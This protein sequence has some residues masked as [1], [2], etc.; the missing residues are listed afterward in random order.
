MDENPAVAL[1][2]GWPCIGYRAP[3]RIYIPGDEITPREWDELDAEDI[4]GPWKDYE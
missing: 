4:W 3:H 2:R 1:V